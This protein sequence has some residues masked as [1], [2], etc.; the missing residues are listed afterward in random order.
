MKIKFILTICICFIIPAISF[1][2][3]LLII[4]VEGEV[5]INRHNSDC[6]NPFV[7]E[8]NNKCNILNNEDVIILTKGS[9]I[10]IIN[11]EGAIA[12]L[13]N[14]GQY[15]IAQVNKIFDNPGKSGKL[16]YRLLKIIFDPDN[17]CSGVIGRH[18]GLDNE[19]KEKEQN[20]FKEFMQISKEYFK[21]DPGC[22]SLKKIP[23][24]E[25]YKALINATNGELTTAKKLLKKNK[26]QNDF[27]KILSETIQHVE[28]K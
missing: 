20:D 7:L 23:N 24:H 12:S 18:A 28:N 27:E 8:A 9:K 4:K 19:N 3:S 22:D 21:I 16:L 26:P 13:N 11:N 5:T 10:S 17:N 6:D 2:Q 1:A 25:V 14:T 15:N